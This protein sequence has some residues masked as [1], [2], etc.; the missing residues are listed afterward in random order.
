MEVSNSFEDIGTP[1]SN[2]F[3]FD[4]LCFSQILLQ[5]TRHHL[6]GNEVYALV[7]VCI[8]STP[9]VVEVDDIFVV[10]LAQQGHLVGDLVE[11]MFRQS[12]NVE[13]VPCYLE[14]FLGIECFVNSFVGALAK[15]GVISNV[16]SIR[17]GLDVLL[18]VGSGTRHLGKGLL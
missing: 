11:I 3:E 16:T 9:C 8:V 14:G 7:A 17:A 1:S 18:D 4:S 6:L 2:N 15:N 12:V 13:F 10:D 5:S